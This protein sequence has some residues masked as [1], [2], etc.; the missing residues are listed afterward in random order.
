M[1]VSALPLAIPAAP[2]TISRPSTSVAFWS[3]TEAMLPDGV[4]NVTLKSMPVFSFQV[5]SMKPMVV[6][7]EQLR[8]YTPVTRVPRITN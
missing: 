2:V 8:Q 4:A 1:S 3:S 7:S 5:P 6:A